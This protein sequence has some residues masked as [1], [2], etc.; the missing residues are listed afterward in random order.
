M[1]IGVVALILGLIVLL[2]FKDIDHSRLRTYI[3]T[4]AVF[5]ELFAVFAIRSEK[6]FW[7][8]SPF[9][10]KVLVLAVIVSILL[11]LAAIYTPLNQIL[12]TV[13]LNLAEWG[14]IIGLSAFS[15]LI[16][17]ITKATKLKEYFGL[18]SS[19]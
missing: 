3:F 17:E 14:M 13:P 1:F 12:K 19:N 15:Y 7:Q 8:E 6:P 11:Q 9:K 5:I 18:F 16:I 2:I 4:L 10:N